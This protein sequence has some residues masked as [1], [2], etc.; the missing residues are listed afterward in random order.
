MPSNN[1][2]S[3][4]ARFTGIVGGQRTRTPDDVQRC[5]VLRARLGEQQRAVP[6]IPRRESGAAGYRHAGGL[7]MQPAGDHQVQHGEIVVLEHEN[8]ALAEA[9]HVPDRAPGEVGDRRVRRAE[10]KRAADPQPVEPRAD[11]PGGEGV[12][13]QHDV[14]QLGHATL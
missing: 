1:R 4:R 6:E 13:I 10:Q 8:D 5:P 14:R 3:V 2:G 7:P 11:Q 12:E 9:A